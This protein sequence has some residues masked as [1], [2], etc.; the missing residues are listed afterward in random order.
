MKRF[1][2]KIWLSCPTM[3]DGQELKW[4][5]DAFDKNWITTAGDSGV[6]RMVF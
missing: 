4:I 3:H 5:K 2:Q 6:L 1:E